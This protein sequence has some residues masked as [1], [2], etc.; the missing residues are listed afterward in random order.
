MRALRLY[1]RP[2]FAFK[3]LPTS[4]CVGASLHTVQLPPSSKKPGRAVVR[5]VHLYV[6]MFY[7]SFSWTKFTP[8]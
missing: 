5:F 1:E 6:P 2:G 7:L 8:L 3:F 4:L